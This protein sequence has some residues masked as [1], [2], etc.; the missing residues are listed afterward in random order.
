MKLIYPAIIIAFFLS[1]SSKTNTQTPSDSIYLG[2][3]VEKVIKNFTEAA[4]KD[5][6]IKY[7]Q[8]KEKDNSVSHELSANGI[9]ITSAVIENGEVT[10]ILLTLPFLTGKDIDLLE[11]EEFKSKFRKGNENISY[12]SNNHYLL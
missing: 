2:D 11:I 4:S 9:P 12:I 10:Y 8:F 6:K 3:P 7:N 1:S 5:T